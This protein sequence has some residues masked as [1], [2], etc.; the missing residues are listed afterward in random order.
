MEIRRHTIKTNIVV[1]IEQDTFEIINV[2]ELEQKLN[3]TKPITLE[4]GTKC[5]L[6]FHFTGFKL[7]KE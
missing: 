5:H 3:L 7:D 2:V 6:R 4:D 1:T